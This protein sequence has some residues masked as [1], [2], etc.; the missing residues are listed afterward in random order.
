MNEYCM[1]CHQDV[2]TSH[3]HSVHNFSSFNN[4]PYAF[5]VKQTRKFAHERDGNVQASRWCAGCHD[6]VPFLSGAFEDSRFDQPDYDVSKDPLGSASITCTVCHGIS[7][8][9]T[10]PRGTLTTP[11]PRSRALP[12]YL[13]RQ[14]L[15]EMGELSSSSRQSPRSTRPRCSSRCTSRRNSVQPATR[16]NLPP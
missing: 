10:K 16:F 6:P 12:L 8:V 7:H 5:S 2:Y 3:T 4:P 13:Q 9:N 15:P 1:S 14:L 11:F